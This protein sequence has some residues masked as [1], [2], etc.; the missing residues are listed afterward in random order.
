MLERIRLID[1]GHNW[2]TGTHSQYQGKLGILRQFESEFGVR[3]LQA[4]HLSKPP[5]PPAIPIMWAQQHYSLRPGTRRGTAPASD[6]ITFAAVRGLRSAANQFFSWDLLQAHPE[7]STKDS[8]S[9]AVVTLGCLPTDSLGFAFMSNGMRRRLGDAS[10]PS[11]AIL[12]RHVQW[13]DA[14]LLQAYLRSND[15]EHRAE[16]A[17]AAL[18]NLAAW[19]GWLRAMEVFSLQW[20]DVTVLEPEDGPVMD[21]PA[22]TGAVSFRLLPQTKSDRTKTADVILAYNTSS[23]FSLG[24]WLHRLCDSLGVAEFPT[25]SSDLFVDRDGTRWTSLYFRS[26]YLI[27]LLEMQRKAGDSHLTQFDGSPGNSLADMFWSLHSYRRGGR[28][29][30]SRCRPGCIRKATDQE[31][32][33]HGRW[34]ASRSSMNMPTLYLEWP[35]LDRIAITL[36]CM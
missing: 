31:V 9:R 32:A 33:E 36:L 3:V 22:M 19:L 25:D 35:P 27:P 14:F 34:R 30:V 10:K 4:T 15:P 21:L 24:L 5:S 11:K 18:V 8:A 2:S 13:I 26:T 23:G 7:T 20:A 12:H 17:R 16:L 29:H 6:G 28:T 1:M